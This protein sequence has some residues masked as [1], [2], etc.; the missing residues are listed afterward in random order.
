MY[1]RVQGENLGQALPA[2]RSRNLTLSQLSSWRLLRRCLDTDDLASRDNCL[3]PEDWKH[4]IEALL[5][6]EN[7][8]DPSIAA[9]LPSSL[10][11]LLQGHDMEINGYA[12]PYFRQG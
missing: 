4:T 7:D 1:S 12:A 8:S 10:E 5:R 6:E 2:A 9:Y 11:F 3:L